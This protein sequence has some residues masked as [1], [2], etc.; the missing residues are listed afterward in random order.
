MIQ[1]IDQTKERD[2][3]IKQA[4]KIKQKTRNNSH[5]TLPIF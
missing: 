1:K 4:I 3:S 2:Q 5:I